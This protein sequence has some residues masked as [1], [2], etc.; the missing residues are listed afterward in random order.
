MK[1]EENDGRERER[2]RER[3]YFSLTVGVNKKLTH[4]TE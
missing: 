2:E 3:E 1:E 4:R